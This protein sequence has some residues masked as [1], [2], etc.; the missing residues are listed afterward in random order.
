M[1][2]ETLNYQRIKNISQKMDSHIENDDSKL[3]SYCNSLQK[4]KGETPFLTAQLYYTIGTGYFAAYSRSIE[5]EW[6]SPHIKNPLI[7]YG[8]LCMN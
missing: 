5:S 4:S 7:T 1:T 3:I 8:K 2:E 6:S